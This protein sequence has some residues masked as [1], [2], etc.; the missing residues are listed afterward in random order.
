MTELLEKYAPT[1]ETARKL[2]AAKELFVKAYVAYLS[3]NRSLDH[4]VIR[5][6]A[7]G[8][9]ISKLV[10]NIPLELLAPLTQLCQDMLRKDKNNEDE[11]IV[12]LHLKMVD[13]LDQNWATEFQRSALVSSQS[14]FTS[15]SSMPHFWDSRADD[16]KL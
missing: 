1:S 13:P 10:T 7:G 8:L 3:D 4:L 15:S 5:S 2:L 12:L 9:Q 14:A 6:M 11:A 16:Q